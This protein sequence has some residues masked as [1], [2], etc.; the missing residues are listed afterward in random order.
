MPSVPLRALCCC[1][2]GFL[3]CGSR[4]SPA[5]LEKLPLFDSASLKL[6]ST[7][8][9]TVAVSTDRTRDASASLHW[10]VSVDFQTGEP[11]YPIGWPR[12][13]RNF[14]TGPLRDWSGWDYLHFWV[15]TATNREKLPGIPAGLGL[16]TPERSSA[17]QRP[18][19]ELKAN[20]WIEIRIPVAQIPRHHD[21]RQ[22]QFH[23]AE[24]NYRHGD[25]LDFFISD[26]ALTRHSSPT[27]LAFAPES[28]IHFTDARL[29][30]LRL[31]LAGVPAQVT[32]ALACELVIGDRV[33][34]RAN[35]LA[36]RGV[37]TLPFNLGFASLP[38]GEYELRATLPGQPAPAIAKVRF[39]D[40]PWK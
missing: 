28:G 21:V 24:S 16:H 22:I 1:G 17:F 40:S 20:A 27:L 26:L 9:S 33:A 23:I 34:A 29:I 5:P 19:S 2:L 4:A 7:A 31:Q 14:P 39:V 8:E 11:K 35:F 38:A 3:A 30:P 32:T 10:H 6:W 13:N 12:V 36:A 15:Y 25:T 37:Q 18:L